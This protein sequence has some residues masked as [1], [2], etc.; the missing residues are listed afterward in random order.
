MSLDAATEVIEAERA[1]I[2][3]EIHDAL[4]PLIFAASAAVQ[5]CLDDLAQ[6]PEAKLAQQPEADNTAQRLQQA[7]LWLQEALQTGRRILTQTHPPELANDTWDHAAHSTIDQ[8]AA[9]EV[10]IRWQVSHDSVRLPDAI[11]ATCY[12]IVVEAVRNA[13][14]HGGATE[15]SITAGHQQEQLIVTVTDNG[16]GFD[17]DKIPQDRFGIR[18]MSGRA[19]LMG[20]KL[21]VESAPGGPTTVC[22]VIPDPSPAERS[23][24]TAAN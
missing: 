6:Q 12:R 5:R 16:S 3:H 22:C 24:H 8:L 18:V 17:A 15:I 21:A 13:I 4:L 7:S 14:R 19:R 11:A 20:G 23:A 10:K 9:A 1:Q 2:S